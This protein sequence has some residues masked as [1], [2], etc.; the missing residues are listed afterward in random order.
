M[1]RSSRQE[2]AKQCG[3]DTPEE[4]DAWLQGNDNP[5]AGG[6]DST[7]PWAFYGICIL[8]CLCL[9]IASCAGCNPTPVPTPTPTPVPD[10]PNPPVTIT[11]PSYSDP[12]PI[13]AWNQAMEL[14]PAIGP[15]PTPNP[16]GPK[17]GD[18]CPSCDGKK[19]VGDGTIMT[20]CL[21]CK[22]DG[23]VDEGDPILS[24]DSELLTTLSEYPTLSYQ[25]YA[26]YNP[27][28]GIITVEPYGD[29]PQELSLKEV[30]E[31]LADYKIIK[32][33][34]AE[35]DARCQC[36]KEQPTD[37]SSSPGKDPA[38]EE[39]TEEAPVTQY[40][41][42]YEGKPWLWDSTQSAFVDSTTGWKI[43]IP[44]PTDPATTPAI[45]VL[46]EQIPIEQL[47]P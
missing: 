22:A 17:V 1:N 30:V 7:N 11:I 40:R 24:G 3:F 41:I 33:Q 16:T 37:P 43:R 29:N 26:S 31:A 39:A 35:L 8:I 25:I 36:G 21:D 46:G 27:E 5:V 15:S 10:N 19:K 38:T 47:K 23:K 4:L 18:I 28:T 42:M 12:D 44:G 20:D 9:A 14:T 34:I 6:I 2:E 32:Q 45:N 13:F